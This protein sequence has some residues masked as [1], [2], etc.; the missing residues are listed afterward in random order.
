MVPSRTPRE[1]GDNVHLSA[2]R[3]I[4]GLIMTGVLRLAAWQSR[5]PAEIAVRLDV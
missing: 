4:H 2:S 5:I 3:D 1:P